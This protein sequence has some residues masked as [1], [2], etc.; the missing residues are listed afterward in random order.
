M[1]K[2]GD[3]VIKAIVIVIAA[4]LLGIAVNVVSPK[5]IPWIYVPK[6]KIVVDNIEIPI[7]TEARA[8]EY[9][10]DGETIFLDTREAEDYSESHIKGAISF[11]EPEKEDQ[12]TRFESRLP[13]D[14]R[15]ILYCNGPECHMAEN[16]AIFL[17]KLGY[18]GLMVMTA[19]MEGWESAGYPIATGR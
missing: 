6:T 9:L 2:F 13:R 10:D 3:I 7:I 18:T 5:G 1:K 19:G 4:S 16:V 17:A 12:Y 8:R 11:P 15:I 14:A